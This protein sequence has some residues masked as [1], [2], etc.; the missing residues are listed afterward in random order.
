MAAKSPEEAPGGAA[1]AAGPSAQGVGE[2]RGGLGPLSIIS[3]GPCPLGTSNLSWQRL[4]W[5]RALLLL[6]LLPTASAPQEWPSVLILLGEKKNSV[7]M[8]HLPWAPLPPPG[9]PDGDRAEN[10]VSG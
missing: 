4:A 2:G 3:S 7:K 5:Q 9:M 1:R 6:S 10:P 8:W